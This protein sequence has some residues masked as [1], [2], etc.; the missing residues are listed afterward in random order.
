MLAGIRDYLQQRGQATLA[1]IASH[2]RISPE[3]ARQMLEVWARKGKVHRR[4][5]TAACGTRCSQC[6]PAATE[7]WVWSDAD[8]RPPELPP[9]CRGG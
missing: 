2:F 6:D 8:D 9:G 7:I 1:D 4:A 5:A 3:V